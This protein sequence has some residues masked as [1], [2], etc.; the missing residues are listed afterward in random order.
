MDAR[1]NFARGTLSTGYDDAATSIA[2]ASGHGARFPAV[3]FNATWFNATDY[4]NP[5]DDPNVEIVRVTNIATDTLTV[6]RA[7]EGTAA[8]TKNAGGKTYK[9][10]A[11]I[12]KKT[13]DDAESELRREVIV[14]ACSDETTELTA[15]TAKVTFRMPFAFTFTEIPRASVTA[16]ATGSVLTIDINEGGSSILSTK[17][18]VDV[19]EETS[20]SAAIAA[21][22]SDTALADDAEITIDLDTVGST[23]GGAGLKLTF[24]GT[25]TT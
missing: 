24:I 11:G 16:A 22:L 10:V 15:G 8:S 9:L 13:L 14:I 18:T 3:P 25:R 20:T 19:T 21:V 5:A 1:K 6:T 7:Q 12:T 4:P 17:L 23:Y 2:L